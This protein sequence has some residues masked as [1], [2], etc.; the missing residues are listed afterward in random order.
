[1]KV[2]VIGGEMGPSLLALSWAGRPHV[3]ASL[4]RC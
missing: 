4:D 3:L 2:E 1:M